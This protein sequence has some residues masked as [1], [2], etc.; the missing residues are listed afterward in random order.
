MTSKNKILQKKCA[1]LLLIC[2]TTIP[3][4]AQLN[5]F[6]ES[7]RID[8]KD[9]ERA[10]KVIS[11]PLK[12]DLVFPNPHKEAQWYPNAS[13]GLFMHWGI[14]SVV[15][16]QPSWDMIAHYRYGGKVAPPERYYALAD[17]FN[18]QN[19]DPNKWLKSAK[20]AGF[21]YAV[22]TT[23]HHDGYALWPSKYGIGTKQ[24]MGGRD[25]IQTYVDACRQNGL[26]VGFYFSPRDWHFPG[27]M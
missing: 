4:S 5:S 20:E 13:L 14:H 16:A 17:E 8:N 10:R 22:L 15:G 7:Y 2:A 19:Y 12:G 27:L 23:K 11:T 1:I 21:T 3:L 9:I 24:Y 26:K 25:L 6:P 18:P